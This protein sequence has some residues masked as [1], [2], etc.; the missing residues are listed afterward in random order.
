MPSVELKKWV[1]LHLA[2]VNFFERGPVLVA[3]ARAVQGKTCK[4]QQQEEPDP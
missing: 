2:C 4:A 1:F 3:I